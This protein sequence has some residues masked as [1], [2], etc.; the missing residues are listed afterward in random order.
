M[1]WPSTRRKSG[2]MALFFEAPTERLHIIVFVGNHYYNFRL[3][4]LAIGK[5]TMHNG[6]CPRGAVA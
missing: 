4:I 6:W 5:I 1:D 3:L 2:V